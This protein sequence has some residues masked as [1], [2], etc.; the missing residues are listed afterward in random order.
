MKDWN[1][2][3]WTDYWMEYIDGVGRPG[4]HIVRPLKEKIIKQEK[5]I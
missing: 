5:M 3:G 4:D 1:K 2:D